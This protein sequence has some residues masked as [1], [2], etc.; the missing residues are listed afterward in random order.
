MTDNGNGQKLG[1]IQMPASTVM[2]GDG[3]RNAPYFRGQAPGTCPT[4]E[5]ISNWGCI[6][7]RHNDGANFGFCDGHAKWY[8]YQGM[9]GAYQQGQVIWAP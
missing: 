2:M 7:A 1:T 8:S 5:G 3:S 9:V 4:N 6:P